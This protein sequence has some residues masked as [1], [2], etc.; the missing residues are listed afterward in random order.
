ADDLLGSG[1]VVLLRLVL[2][3]PYSPAFASQADVL[4]VISGVP[5]AYPGLELQDVVGGVLEKAAV[6]ANDQHAGP[7]EAQKA[8]Q[9]LDRIEIE[10]IRRFVAQKPCAVRQD[11][12][13]KRQAT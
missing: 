1:D 7:G 12:L 11:D 5:F 2:L 10:L 3:L 8:F 13:A 9:P 6:M 4:L